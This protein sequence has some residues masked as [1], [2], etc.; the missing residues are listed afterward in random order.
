MGPRILILLA[1]MDLVATAGIWHYLVQFKITDTFLFTISGAW[2]FAICA[3]VALLCYVS[4][5]LNGPSRSMLSSSGA[6]R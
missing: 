4:G 1:V 2:V 3:L 5:E 6:Q